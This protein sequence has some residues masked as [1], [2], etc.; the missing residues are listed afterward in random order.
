MVPIVAMAGLPEFAGHRV[1]KTAPLPAVEDY[2]ALSTIASSN[3]HRRR[4]AKPSRTQRSPIE[5]GGLTASDH[6]TISATRHNSNT[7]RLAKPDNL[8]KQEADLWR[9]VLPYEPLL[10]SAIQ[11]KYLTAQTAVAA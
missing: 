2:A 8:E 10:P 11:A 7:R 5:T 4:K 1:L 9:A 3:S 6:E